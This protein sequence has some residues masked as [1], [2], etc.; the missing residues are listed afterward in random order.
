MIMMPDLCTQTQYCSSLF[1]EG[2]SSRRSPSGWDCVLGMQ[3]MSVTPF[4][5]K[6]TGANVNCSSAKI[7]KRWTESYVFPRSIPP[8]DSGL[9]RAPRIPFGLRF[10]PC[11]QQPIHFPPFVISRDPPPC[12]TRT[13]RRPNRT[14]STVPALR[15]LLLATAISHTRLWPTALT[16]DLWRM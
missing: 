15:L 12:P 14:M 10:R 8:P 6:R 1:R 9:Y 13:L 11:Q 2:L 4:D 3:G 5:N 16:M 7:S